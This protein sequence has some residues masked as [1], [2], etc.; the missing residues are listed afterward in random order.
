MVKKSN[1]VP[2]KAKKKTPPAPPPDR[3][4]TDPP[5]KV[6]PGNPFY[7]PTLVAARKEAEEHLKTYDGAELYPVDTAS[8]PSVPFK[9]SPADKKAEQ[10]IKFEAIQR[11][12]SSLTVQQREKIRLTIL[13]LTKKKIPPTHH[14]DHELMHQAF[15]ACM[16]ERRFPFPAYMDFKAGKASIAYTKN[17]QVVTNFIDTTFSGIN[18]AERLKLMMLMSRCFISYIEDDVNFEGRKTTPLM[19]DPFGFAVCCAKVD[20]LIE[21]S[22]PGYLEAGMIGMI[23]KSYQ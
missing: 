3:W 10:V 11:D 20:V 22:F 23:L 1:P 21:R 15:R 18:K 9:R 5:G 12:I 19:L 14:S 17:I 16:R 13:S 4:S 7:S 6:G 2:A 8:R